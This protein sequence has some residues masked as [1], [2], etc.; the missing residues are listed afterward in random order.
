MKVAIYSANFGNYRNELNNIHNEKI[1]YD[2]D[3]DYYFFTDKPNVK[4]KK[5]KVIRINLQSELNFMDKYRHTSKH[6]RWIVPNILKKYDIIVWIDS[7]LLKKHTGQTKLKFKKNNIIELL[8]QN[9]NIIYFN[10]HS[11]RNN[12]LDEL[13]FTIKLNMEN[14]TKYHE[15]KNIIN[16]INFKSKLP[17][18]RCMICKNNDENRNL[19]KEIYNMQLKYEFRRDQNVVQ[20]VFFKEK[21]E[22]KLCFFPSWD[23]LNE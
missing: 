14:K 16:N 12:P 21:C 23:Y 10:E 13:E 1:Y 20:Y 9:E 22:Y 11:S 7:S 15:F 4:S 2:K 19:L 5:W 6:I 17:S 8:K 3:I 18:C